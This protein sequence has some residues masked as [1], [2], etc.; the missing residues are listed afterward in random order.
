[1]MLLEMF[2]SQWCVCAC[3]CVRVCLCVCVCVCVC[4]CLIVYVCV[5]VCVLATTLL[6]NITVDLKAIVKSRTEFLSRILESYSMLLVIC[7]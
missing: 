7:P 6:H 5:C 2:R 4:E 3:V 1:M